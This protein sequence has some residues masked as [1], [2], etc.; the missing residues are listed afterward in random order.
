MRLAVAALLA[1]T[2]LSACQPS[3]PAQDSTATSTAHSQ[4]AKQSDAPEVS[5]LATATETPVPPSERSDQLPPNGQLIRRAEVGEQ[6][7]Y[8]LTIDDGYGIQPFDQIL[9]ELRAREIKATFFLVALASINLGPERL[10]QL[11]E[12]GHSIAYHS[13]GHDDLHVLEGWGRQDW[14]DDFAAWQ[15]VMQDLLGAEGFAAAYRPYA[16]APYGLF[17]L[18]FLKMTEELELIPVGWSN[19][20]G[21]MNRGLVVKPGDIFLLHVRYPDAEI[22]PELLDE[23]GLQ[24]VSLDE[25]FAAQIPE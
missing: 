1:A 11:V 10:A 19:D 4:T 24:V 2:L 14:V 13:Y 17:N 7:I 20:P 15:R 12:D 5:P 23:I 16:R 3:S 9:A 8:A 18:A 21:D 22:L 25:L 6:A